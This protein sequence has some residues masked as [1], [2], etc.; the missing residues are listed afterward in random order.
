MFEQT[1]RPYKES[2]AKDT[3]D[4][5]KGILGKV[6]LVPRI[7]FKGN[8]YPEIFS[9]RLQL[10][11]E[12]G[13][14]GTNGKGRNEEYSLAS[15]YAEFLERL[16]NGIYST[17]SRT[18]IS[19][20][21]NDYGFYYTPDEKYLSEE[22]FSRL[23]S[24]VLSDLILSLGEGKKRFISSYFERLKINNLP[25]IVTVPFY[26]TENKCDI[27]LPVNML[28]LTLG[29][30]G[31]A[32]GNTKSEAIFQ[33]LS[34]LNE[35]WGAAEVFYKQMTPPTVPVE[36]LK[37]FKE[38]AIIENIEK[39]GK[40]KVTVKDFSAG[41]R[42][43]SLG[44]I[45]ET[46]DRT[47]YRLNVGSDTSFQFALSRCLTEIF[48]GK[49]DI[50][51]FD[52]QMIDIPKEAPDYFKNDERMELRMRYNVFRDFIVDNSGQ[53]PPSLFGS[54]P[55][56]A[57]DPSVFAPKE[58]YDK[59]VRDMVST[60]HKNG[61]NVYIRDVSFMG[62][63][64]VLVYIP[65]VS[66]LG[67]KIILPPNK[68]KTFNTIEMDRIE[69]LLFD[70]ENCSKEELRLIA[71]TLEAFES[72]TSLFDLFNINFK[73]GSPW[74]K[75]TIPFFLTLAWHKL[76]DLKKAEESIKDFIENRE[77]KVN[78][79]YYEIV[80]KYFQL[81]ITGCSEKEIVAKLKEENLPEKVIKLVIEDLSNPDDAFKHIK[82]PKCPACSDCSLTDDCLTKNQINIFR[83]VFPIMKENPINQS[84]LSREIFH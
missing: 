74:P 51:S 7:V 72:K 1:G 78:S 11:D 80:A 83:K 75:I 21:K 39:S 38:Y 30:N 41:K 48:Q 25:G 42:I 22:E 58:S 2:N 59:E 55:D 9:V 46:V 37:K 16:Q 73:G 34:E 43:P 68:S 63:P 71:E 33:A 32:A 56:Y 49:V 6:D 15:G 4:K 53:Y 5:I 29:S 84:D 67:R 23:P 62:F 3:I 24:Q 50:E 81:K 18:V 20:L 64:S 61:Y 26:D 36:F 70:F 44:V 10:D 60:F 82:F 79:D 47:K 77:D 31:M 8:P 19:R 13:G 12:L 27:Y 52:E 54:T 69:P 35:R 65:E 14:F 40:Y 57:F 76:G 17:F 66:A 28:L 45:I